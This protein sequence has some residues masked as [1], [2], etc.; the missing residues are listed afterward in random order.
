MINTNTKTR[1]LKLDGIDYLKALFDLMKPR[2]MSLA[3]FTCVVGLLIAPSNIDYLYA[4]LSIM[5]VALG[6]GAAGALNCWYE[7]DVDSVMS[8]TCLRPI[9]TGKLR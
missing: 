9:P 3:I 2:V 6:S 7:A 1:E 5:A 4:T 8:R